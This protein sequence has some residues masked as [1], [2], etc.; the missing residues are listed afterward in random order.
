MYSITVYQNP[1]KLTTLKLAYALALVGGGYKLVFSSLGEVRPVWAIRSRR[2]KTFGLVQNLFQATLG[3]YTA[4]QSTKVTEVRL[5]YCSKVGHI[6]A[7]E[8]FVLEA[9]GIIQN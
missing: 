5:L 6:T 9:L 2:G 7:G 1:W 8:R 3:N 4:I